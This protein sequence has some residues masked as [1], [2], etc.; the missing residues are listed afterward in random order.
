MAW[1]HEKEENWLNEMAAQG[2][3]LVDTTPFRYVFEQ[4]TPGEYQYRLELLAHGRDSEESRTYVRFMEETGAEYITTYFN[5]WAYFRKRVAD[6]PFEI[7]SDLDSKLQHFERI[8]TLLLSITVVELLVLVSQI[9]WFVL[10]REEGRYGSM[11]V[12]VGAMLVILAI[13]IFLGVGLARVHAQIRRLR[14]ER[15]IHE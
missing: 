7:F 6:G 3:N 14:R 9:A 2:W 13:T 5:G 12:F 15:E 11:G 8:R 1:E 10:S 4:G